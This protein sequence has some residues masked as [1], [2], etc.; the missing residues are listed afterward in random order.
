[1]TSKVYIGLQDND[2]SRYIVEAIEE[3]NPDATVI[4]Q[5]AMV[6]IECAGQL[7]VK[8]ETVE[9]KYGQ[10]WDMQELHLNLITLG[11]NVDEDEDRLL[12]HWNS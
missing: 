8:R 2:M 4:Y 3:D 5:P 7:V 9:E 10:Q 12:L 11:G 1:M 6:R